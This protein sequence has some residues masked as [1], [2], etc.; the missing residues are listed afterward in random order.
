MGFFTKIFGTQN[1]EKNTCEFCGTNIHAGKGMIT[2][3]RNN[4]EKTAKNVI[5]IATRKIICPICGSVFCFHC[6]Y[7]EGQKRGTG[8]T[9][10]PRC[11]RSDVGDQIR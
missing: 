9:H 10:C 5:E 4:P 2:L 8:N 7:L 3:Y 6:A 11:G 1:E